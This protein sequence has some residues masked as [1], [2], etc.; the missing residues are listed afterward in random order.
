M[1]DTKEIR[2]LL[3]DTYLSFVFWTVLTSLGMCIWYFPLWH[4]GISGYEVALFADMAPVLLGIRPL[5]QLLQRHR[6][7]TAAI[8][9]VGIGAYAVAKP[10]E[11]LLGVAIGAG[12]VMLSL[13]AM[14]Y[15]DRVSTGRLDR[16]IQTWEAGLVLSVAVRMVFQTNNPVWPTMNESN[17]GWNKTGILLGVLAL[18]DVAIRRSDDTAA[19]Q[20]SKK[21]DLPSGDA[22]SAK[23][24]ER[25]STAWGQAAVGFGGLLFALHSMCSDSAIIGRWSWDGYPSTGP[26]PVPWGGLVISALAAGFSAGHRIELTTGMLWWGVAAVGAGLITF[27]S[28]WT[29]FGGGIVL[30]IYL[31]SVTRSILRAVSRCPPGRTLAAGIMWYNVLVLAHV[32]VVAYEFVPGGPILRERTWVVMAATMASLY[33]GVRAA[34]ASLAPRGSGSGGRQAVPAKHGARSIVWAAVGLGWAAMLMRLPAASRTPTPF[35]PEERLMTSAIWTVHFDLDNDMWLAENKIIQ[36]VRDLQVDV[37]GFLE[38]DTERIIMGGRDWTQRVAEEL[39]YYV[40]YGPSPRK[41][42]WGCAMI[43]KF[44]IKRSTHHLL[45]SPVGELACAIH[46][47]LDVFGREVD[48]IVS[49]NGQHENLLDRRLQTTELA[50]VM[51]ESPNPF[52]FT[53]YVVTKPRKEIYNILYSGGRI[54]DIEPRDGDRWCQYIG[55]RGVK[56]TGYARISRGTITDTEIQAAKFQV[57]APGEN[58][59]DWTPSYARVKEDHYPEAYRFPTVFRGKGVRGHYYHVFNEPLYYD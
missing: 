53:G 4:M 30:A 47:T 13:G 25:G 17:G 52:I 26:Q 59:T 18:V 41:H 46:A 35:H 43:S 55:F 11:R 3:A 16:D 2:H 19:L 57:P 21:N 14:L 10:E 7:I 51:R 44:R 56:R 45:P 15:E 24:A 22:K 49:H 36:T 39:N 28:G 42:T 12:G 31:G 1:A 50:R 33:A 8:G 38:S 23:S 5:R 37:M 27:V 40:D 34:R 29:G 48:V 54:H 32:W 6:S 58:V 20:E 9:L